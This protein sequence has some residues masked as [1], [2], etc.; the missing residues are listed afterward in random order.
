MFQTIRK[1]GDYYTQHGAVSANIVR[2]RV[3]SHRRATN[4]P[5]VRLGATIRNSVDI[6][7]KWE[8]SRN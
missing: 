5:T 2:Q 1:L 8:V 3:I 7:K 6:A 4:V